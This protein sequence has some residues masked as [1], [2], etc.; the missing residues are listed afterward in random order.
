MQ[1]ILFLG[2]QLN[3]YRFVQEAL[4]VRGMTLAYEKLSELTTDFLPSEKYDLLVFELSHFREAIPDSVFTLCHRMATQNI[5]T[6]AILK[7]DQVRSRYR[8]VEAGLTDYLYLPFDKLDLQIRVRNLISF[9]EKG[10]VN[11]GSEI[12]FHSEI[13]TAFLEMAALLVEL[14]RNI[15]KSD[16][17]PFI[18]KA[19]KAIQKVVHSNY[20]LFFQLQNDS[21]LHLKFAFPELPGMK[22]LAIDIQDVLPF[23]KA[24]R[25]GEYTVLNQINKQNK[26]YLYF[27]S[28]LNLDVRAF[29]VFPLKISQKVQA[30]LSIFYT[31][32]RK[33]SDFHFR[34]LQLIKFLIEI[35]FLIENLRQQSRQIS[36]SEEWKYSFKFLEHVINQ[37]N[38]GIL[39]IDKERKIR[40]LNKPAEELINQKSQD[41]LFKQIET[42]LGE[43]NT[44]VLFQALEEKEG[45]YKRPE[46]EIERENEESV[47]IGFTVN[48]FWDQD[49][50][51]PGY[52]ISLKDIT[53]SKE[54]QEE[55]RRMDRL[56]SLG[57]MASGIAHEI[58]NPLAGIK[59]IAQTF[60]EELDPD[61]PKT[62]FV[63]RIIKQV[64]RLD[65]MLKS[66]FSYAKPQKPN[67]QFHQIEDILQEV[68]ALL[69]QNLLKKNIKLSRS[70]T[71]NI[72][73]LYV[74][75]SQIQQVLFNL[76][77]NSIESIENDGKIEISIEPVPKEYRKFQRKP[78]YRMITENPYVLI[79][80]Q[81]NGCG[82][83]KENMQKIFNPFFTTK[84]FGTGLGL[85]IVYQIVKENNGVIYFDS[86]EGQGTDCY[87]FLPAYSPEKQN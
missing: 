58:R 28:V 46:I 4:A 20:I 70:F 25:L 9:S 31:E 13:R 48:E 67:R 26:L 55:M 80:I 8:L 86:K 52:L 41:I 21:Q 3:S 56:A 6:L 84:T 2:N 27:K 61:D 12:T 10:D 71:A 11:E 37:L 75:A 76:I 16:T 81:D 5:P 24:V 72:P 43:R 87:L 85:S 82:I 51:E 22:G 47:L 59:A 44:E 45:A 65:D 36:R 39:V 38:F 54:L 50:R 79:R 63:K 42:V 29:A 32:N 53:Y 7:P 73:P 60:E 19:L 77:L 23:N 15:L 33:I 30:V 1:K 78:F 64:N 74:D 34:Y 57:V 35:N 18:Q 17:S 40:Y 83:S 14:N 49:T 66:L 68:L 69:K 62:E